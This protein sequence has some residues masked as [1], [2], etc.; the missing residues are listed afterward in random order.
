[1]PRITVVTGH[2][3]GEWDAVAAITLPGLLAY[4]DRHRYDLMDVP[5]VQ[6]AER[7]PASWGKLPALTQ[8][9]RGSDVAVWIDT[10]AVMYPDA[11]PIHEALTPDAWHALV[12]HETPEGTVPGCGVWAV[13][14]AMLP[15]L[16][17]AWSD[18][19]DHR[20]W[21]QAAMHRLMG[22]DPDA[23]PVCQILDTVVWR[24]TVLLDQL[25]SV[26][27]G[28]DVWGPYMRHAPGGRSMVMREAMLREWAREAEAVSA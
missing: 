22:F 2:T 24:H 20:W 14:R 18:Y 5:L 1:M 21:E 26:L 4:C 28:E 23:L 16:R 19:R 17:L 7:R 27:P 25:W 10:D 15:V 8:A 9:L 3:P 13:T 12:V 6:Y 11:P